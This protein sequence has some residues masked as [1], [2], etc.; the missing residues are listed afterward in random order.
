MSVE[1]FSRVSTWVESVRFDWA[2]YK[3][4][5]VPLHVR[6]DQHV[7][8]AGTELESIYVVE[9]GRVRLSQLSSTGE[10]KTVLVVGTNSMFDEFGALQASRCSVTNAIASSDARLMRISMD[11]F[12]H[13]F[14][15]DASFAQFVCQSMSHKYQL[16]LDQLTSLSYTSA[17][18]RIANYLLELAETYGEPRA[19]RYDG[20]LGGKRFHDA[21]VPGNSIQ[22]EDLS[23][24][25][26]PDAVRISI[27]FTHQEMANL[28]GTTRVTV[29]QV[30]RRLEALG[31]LRKEG[32]YFY[33]SSIAEFRRLVEDPKASHTS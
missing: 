26:E 2:P 13:L 30:F 9:T 4:Y 7:L 32:A 33:I 24:R 31:V 1:P 12:H 23:N 21:G 8:H 18:Y 5:G 11:V 6:K 20:T 16:L 27:P 25:P 17:Q 22:S 3:K 28:A 19:E 10:E 15:T 29:A 14:Q